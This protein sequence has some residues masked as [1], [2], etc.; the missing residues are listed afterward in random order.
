M[1]RLVR[2]SV[3]LATIT[4]AATSFAG[5]Y[6]V[7]TS[8]SDSNSGTSTSSPW[9]HAPG[10]SGCSGNC[11]TKKPQAGD[12]IILRGGDVWHYNSAMGVKGLPWTIAG[13]GTSSTPVYYGVDHTW[14]DS[15]ACG[16][17]W[18]RPKLN[19]DNPLSKTAVSACSSSGATNTDL[20]DV[21]LT[22]GIW[23]DMEVFGMC[24]NQSTIPYYGDAFVA[25]DSYNSTYKN[26][27]IHGWTH[28][29]GA[30]SQASAFVGSTDGR[31]NH[32]DGV[33]VDGSDSDP[34]SLGSGYNL[35]DVHN[36]VFRYHSNC[37]IGNG[38]HTYYNNLAEYCYE[39]YDGAHGNVLEWNNESNQ[40]SNFIYNNLIRHNHTAVTLWVCPGPGNNDYYFNNVIYD[41]QQQPFDFDNTGSGG[42]CSVGGTGNYINN[43]FGASGDGTGPGAGGSY[44]ANF[45][46]NYY[47]SISGPGGSPL[48]N[49]SFIQN[50]IAQATARGY[51][52]TGDYIPTS[53]N[54]LGNSTVCPVGAG[55][56][57][58]S[59]CSALAAAG[60]TAEGNALCQDSTVGPNY[61]PVQHRVTG[62]RRTP[63]ARPVSG[64][65]DVGAVQAGTSTS[66]APPPPPAPISPPSGLTA[67][68]N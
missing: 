48:A 56:N 12:Q 11:A 64:A 41:S 33:V 2:F 9:Q 18:C 47:V 36:S 30:S 19:G 22:W 62:N 54:C 5:T 7:S 43:S 26:I 31:V 53:A 60:Y 46:N 39:P 66:T 57:Y 59:V 8:G 55:A 1:R 4:I 15:T 40:A 50:S 65:W 35:Y 3:L 29:A 51:L 52:D 45:R 34:T 14:Y 32:F 44:N 67:I 68:V 38:A 13:T 16:T 21:Q 25:M 49:T 42:V 6:Y 24:W 28:T 10:M 58:T 23:D 63:T 27:Y 61:D 17:S 20:V 37:G